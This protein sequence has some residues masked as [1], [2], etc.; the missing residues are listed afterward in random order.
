MCLTSRCRFFFSFIVTYQNAK[1]VVKKFLLNYYLLLSPG[2]GKKV[3]VNSKTESFLFVH[4]KCE[5]NFSLFI[6]V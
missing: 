1:Q 3:S 6:V 4:K 2:Q 5:L